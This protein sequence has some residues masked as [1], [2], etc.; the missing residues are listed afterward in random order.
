MIFIVMIPMII[1][2]A[3][4]SA[5]TETFA[6]KTYTND[7]AEIVNVP[8]PHIFLAAAAVAVLAIIPLIFLLKKWK[9]TE[10]DEKSAEAR[11][12]A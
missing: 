2:P 6:N 8:P 9:Q 5:V 12:Q 1:G 3:V 7:Y 11:E 10:Q 4:G